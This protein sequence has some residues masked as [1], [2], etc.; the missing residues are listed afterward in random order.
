MAIIVPNNIS[1][2]KGAD[3]WRVTANF[4]N[5][6]SPISSN[7]ERVDTAGQGTLGSVM[8]ESSGVFTFPST[9]IWLVE[10]H[11]TYQFKDGTGLSRRAAIEATTDN[12][13]YNTV[14]RL[15]RTGYDEGYDIRSVQSLIDVTDTSNVKVQFSVTS[16]S[17]NDITLG[18]TDQNH[19][20]FTF[21]RLGDT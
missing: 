3:Q 13:S 21:I 4:T 11:Q 20:F 5:T 9:G 8:T 19:T 14:A 18:N 12:S 7:L 17:T 10:F 16:S 6:A 1:L 15:D 2:K